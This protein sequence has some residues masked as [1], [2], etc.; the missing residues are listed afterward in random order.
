MVQLK[1]ILIQLAWLVLTLIISILIILILWEWNF[2]YHFITVKILRTRVGFSEASLILSTWLLVSCVIFSIREF[3]ADQNRIIGKAIAIIAGIAFII[4][5][6]YLEGGWTSYP[7]L[8]ALGQKQLTPE[9][10]ELGILILQVI[11][12]IIVAILLFWWIRKRALQLTYGLP[13]G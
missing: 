3:G 1:P 4:S 5:L 10:F 12:G 9:T 2:Q 11:A 8:G 13:P 7:P 6:N